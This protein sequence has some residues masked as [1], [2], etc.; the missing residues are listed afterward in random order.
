[1]AV[2]VAA[3]G[4]GTGIAAATAATELEGGVVQLTQRV[5]RYRVRLL[6]I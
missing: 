1:M 6:R 2:A 3:T 5:Q 4:T